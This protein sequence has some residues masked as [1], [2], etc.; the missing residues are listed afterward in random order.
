MP[1][2]NAHLKSGAGNKPKTVEINL[3]ILPLISFYADNNKIISDRIFRNY[4]IYRM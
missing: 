3:E 2:I 1:E 4:F